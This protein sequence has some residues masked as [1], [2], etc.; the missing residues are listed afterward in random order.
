MRQKIKVEQCWNNFIASFEFH[1]LIHSHCNHDRSSVSILSSRS[2]IE[3][4]LILRFL[5]SAKPAYITS[6]N[7]LWLSHRS[8]D[9]RLTHFYVQRHPH[10]RYSRALL[11]WWLC[12]NQ[13]RNFSL[14]RLWYARAIFSDNL[15]VRFS[16]LWHGPTRRHL[17]CTP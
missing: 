7:Q 15:I 8:W 5:R 1:W 11:S 16:I 12:I 14:K 2:L 3:L 10:F 13:K 4:F 9:D 6:T 17:Q